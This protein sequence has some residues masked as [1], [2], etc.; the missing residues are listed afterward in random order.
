M[1]TRM[2]RVRAVLAGAL[3]LGVG[4]TVT[5]A[6]WT[7]QDYTTGSFSTSR[8]VT[9]STTDATGNGWQDNSVSPGATLQLNAGALSPGVTVAAAFGIRTTAGSI[10]GT[11]SLQTPTSTTTPL[12]ALWSS[13]QY[14]VYSSTASAC[15]PTS[16]PSSGSNWIVGGSTTWSALS[17]AVAANATALAAAASSSPGA[18]AWFCFQV[19]LPAGA[20]NTLQGQSLVVTWL[21][22]GTSS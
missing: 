18:P 11:E 1:P 10:G 9:Q 7:S 15:T 12:P 6:A 13:L 17:T 5:L 21:F 20:A 22:S 4:A 2:T 8:F 19:A 3:V 16:S 14:R